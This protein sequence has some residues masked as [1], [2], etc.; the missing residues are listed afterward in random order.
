M[1][2]VTVFFCVLHDKRIHTYTMQFGFFGSIES[3]WAEICLAEQIALAAVVRLLR[4]QNE[5]AV[6][7]L[8]F[9]L[10]FCSAAHSFFVGLFFFFFWR[11]IIFPPPFAPAGRFRY[12]FTRIY[13]TVQNYGV[14]A[15]HRGDREAHPGQAQ[16]VEAPGFLA[17]SFR[18]LH[19]AEV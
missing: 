16:G 8:F 1:C 13:R 18:G 5:R 12:V 11:F 15:A 6:S 10:C 17:G 2:R 4:F 19:Q 3:P 9:F 14:P 7:F